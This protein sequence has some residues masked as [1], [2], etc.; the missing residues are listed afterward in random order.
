MQKA[1]FLDRDGVINIDHGYTHKSEHFKFMPGVF[2]LCSRFQCEGYKI[3]VITNQ[4][5]IGRGFYSEQDFAR[6]TQ[7]MTEKFAQNLITIDGVYW[8]PHHPVH[9]LGEYLQ[10]CA[11]RK[12]QPGMLLQAIEEHQ[13]NASQSVMIGDKPSDLLAAQRAGIKRRILFSPDSNISVTVTDN[14]KSAANEVATKLDL[15]VPY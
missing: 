13:L 8:C 10:N 14:D 4:A 12:P 2:S 6:L 11:C 15:I 5:G 1:L 3:I 7:W 9:A